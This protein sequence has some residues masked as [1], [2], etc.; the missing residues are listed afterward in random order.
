MA[1]S[2]C[3]KRREAMI[4]TLQRTV[5]AAKKA[6]GVIPVGARPGIVK[7]SVIRNGERR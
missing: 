7:N 5:D 3:Q 2:G 6:I 4:T 1:C